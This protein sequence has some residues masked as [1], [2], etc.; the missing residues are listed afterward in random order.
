MARGD[1][2][3]G[4]GLDR[5]SQ[6]RRDLELARLKL[7]TLTA[8]RGNAG[9][10]KSAVRRSEF[11]PLGSLT[12]ASGQIG[13]APTMQEYNALQQDVAGIFNALKRI[14]NILGTASIEKG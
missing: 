13:A 14:S 3:P 7:E 8:E 11:E 2:L 10:S 5:A 6:I 9:R 1:A 4:R 12:L